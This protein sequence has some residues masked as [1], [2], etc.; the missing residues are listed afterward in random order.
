MDATSDGI[1]SLSFVRSMSISPSSSISVSG[2]D[3]SADGAGEWVWRLRCE[4]MDVFTLALVEVL[5]V[6]RLV[7]CRWLY[8]YRYSRAERRNG[9]EGG[10]NSSP[11]S[12]EKSPWSL[13]CDKS[14]FVKAKFWCEVF[15]I[16]QQSKRPRSTALEPVTNPI[17]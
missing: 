2:R 13:E 9:R 6:W 14:R 3:I 1:D 17:F 11:Y 16:K 5:E 8:Q 12:Q 10:Y 15:Q 4:D 7:D